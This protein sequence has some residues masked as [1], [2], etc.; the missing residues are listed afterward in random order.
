MKKIISIF[1]SVLI[2]LGM[3]ISPA[4]S[5]TDSKATETEMRAAWISTVY[6]IDWPSKS[7]YGNAEKQKKE[8]IVLCFNCFFVVCQ[9]IF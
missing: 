7:S 5:V 8:Y 4:F 6:N 9:S 2:M 3:V 1:T